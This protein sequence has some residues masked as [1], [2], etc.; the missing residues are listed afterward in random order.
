MVESIF[1][2]ILIDR[3]KIIIASILVYVIIFSILENLKPFGDK[4]KSNALIA[5]LTAIIVSFTGVVSYA[6]NYAVNWFFIL[7]FIFFLII[8]ILLFLGV[9]KSDIINMA[10][11]NTKP[12][13]IA[14]L[15]LFSVIFIKSFFAV[16]NTFDNSN[17]VANPYLVDTSYNAGG[18]PEPSFSFLGNIYNSIVNVNSDLLYM[19]LFFIGI[20]LV[21][22]FTGRGD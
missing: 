8:L 15:I 2:P 22:I 10:S 9:S 4:T 14:F 3:F 20:G 19:V 21:M 6:I 7:I 18:V 12:L 13:I 11:K 5:L 16:N 1:S 17:Q